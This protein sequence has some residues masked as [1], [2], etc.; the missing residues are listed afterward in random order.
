MH[1]CFRL[2]LKGSLETL[3]MGDCSH[4]GI[5]VSLALLFSKASLTLSQSTSS[6]LSVEGKQ[7]STLSGITGGIQYLVQ[8]LRVDF[9]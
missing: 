1:Q 5:S 4:F 8:H 7:K 3:S 2:P 6:G 9:L